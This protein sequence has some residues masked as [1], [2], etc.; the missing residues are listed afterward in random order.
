VSLLV[1]N[2]RAVRTLALFELDDRRGRQST[3]GGPALPTGEGR[4]PP[5]LEPEKMALRP[6]VD[7]SVVVDE[8]VRGG[9]EASPSSTGSGST[10]KT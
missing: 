3:E 4:A 1:S 6:D 8:G 2:R 7:P 9:P 10:A 5:V